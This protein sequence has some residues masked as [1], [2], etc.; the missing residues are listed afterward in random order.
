MGFAELTIGVLVEPA[1]KPAICDMAQIT[2]DPLPRDQIARVANIA[3]PPEQARF[4]A[5]P[6]DVMDTPR[7]RDGHVILADRNPVGFFAI[8]RDDPAHHDFAPEGA[9]GLRMFSIN[10]ADQ[11]RGIA[12]TACAALAR[13]LPVHYPQHTTCYLTVNC[14][15]PGAHRAYVKGG[16]EDT[17]ARYLG[18]GL[19]PQHIMRLALETSSL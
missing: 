5:L 17:G 1:L 10:H 11:G 12:S 4:S 7:A 13:Y 16:F 8:D 18:G 2:L 14:R 15:N 6:V 9:L 3:L 19:G